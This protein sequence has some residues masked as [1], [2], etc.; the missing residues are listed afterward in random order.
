MTAHLRSSVIPVRAALAALTLWSVAGCSV[1]DTVPLVGDTG[2]MCHTATGAYFLSKSYISLK[3]TQQDVNQAYQL[4]VSDPV[5]DSDRNQMYC[6]DYLASPFADDTV[7]VIRDPALGVL[8]RVSSVNDDKT[9][10]VA[11]TALQIGVIAATG[12]PN[13]TRK[14]R[15][16]TSAADAPTILAD[17]A[18]DPFDRIK[19]AEVNAALAGTYGYCAI[20]DGRTVQGPDIQSYCNSPLNYARNHYVPALDDPPP[21]IRPE[22][23]GRGILYRPNQT[24]HL[25]IL[26]RRDPQSS[27]PWHIF[28]T[29]RIEMP[30]VSPVF[31]IGIERSMFVKRTTTLMFDNGV[32]RD[33]AIEKPS[34]VLGFVEIPLRVVQAVIAI[35]AQIVKVRIKAVN[36][37]QAIADAQA[38]LIQNQAA[39]ANLRS[40][41]LDP[42]GAGI[43]TRALPIRAAPL[44]GSRDLS[45]RAAAI[46][47]PQCMASS[48]P[49]DCPARCDGLARDCQ[50]SDEAQ[51]AACIQTRLSQ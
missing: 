32:L 44:P 1:M 42:T 25:V 38:G 26:R 18:L 43:G 33:I 16:E 51:T 45:Q 14:V 12:N 48:N 37:E 41:L 30:N 36:N 9:K 49:S 24:Y 22:E 13:V 17:Y 11:L 35:P 3:V 34:E 6:L 47:V 2:E 10:D 19:L 20:I 28:Q 50:S 5:A 40:G 29:K 4:V 23:V 7:N 8:L 15:I 46:C 21:A 27:T 39:L 31:S